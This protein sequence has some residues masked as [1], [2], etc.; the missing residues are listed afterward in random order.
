MTPVAAKALLALCVCPPAVMTAMVASS[1]P[2]RHHVAKAVRHALRRP[3]PPAPAARPVQLAAAPCADGPM[4]VAQGSGLSMP[5]GVGSDG[6]TVPPLA[7]PGS[8]AGGLPGAAGQGPLPAFG[9]PE[10]SFAGLVQP[11]LSLPAPPP[12][13]AA[14]EPG[15]WAL[16]TIGFG[17]VGTAIRARRLSAAPAAG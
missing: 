2:A 17:A 8:L 1:P 10:Q 14:P 13:A 16:L 3:E 5:G 7:L 12:M 15:Q 4:Q 11:Q 6:F 9:S